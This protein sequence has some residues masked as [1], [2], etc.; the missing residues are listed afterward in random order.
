MKK[1]REVIVITTVVE[2]EEDI[3]DVTLRGKTTIQQAWGDTFSFTRSVSFDLHDLTKDN[4]Y[5][6]FIQTNL[7]HLFILIARSLR[8]K[9]EKAAE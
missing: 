7:E 9:L 5:E 1:K 3:T 6:M 8:D 4:A 2:L